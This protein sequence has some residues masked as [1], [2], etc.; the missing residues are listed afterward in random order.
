GRTEFTDL[1]KEVAVAVQ[2]VDF[3]PNFFE[4][5]TAMAFKHFAEEAVDIA[6]VEVGL[7]GRLDSTNVIMPEVSV[8]TAI[9]FDH[10]QIL[11]RT[12]DKIAREKAGIFKKGVPAI[13]CEQPPDVERQL[14][15]TADHVGAPLRMVN[16]E[17]EFS[18]R[19]GA[20]D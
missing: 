2:S 15:S 14:R 1:A 3:E 12:L 19:F 16:K 17:I 6:V 7:G 13:T 20:T 4:L 18:F 8:V 10:T 5:I 9:D 11:G